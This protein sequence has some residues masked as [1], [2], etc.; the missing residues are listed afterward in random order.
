LEGDGEAEGIRRTG[1]GER[2]EEQA[3]ERE[4]WLKRLQEAAWAQEHAKRP[5]FSEIIQIFRKTSF[6]EY[7]KLRLIIF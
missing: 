6:I 7:D 2:P 1:K 3:G 5:S 4:A